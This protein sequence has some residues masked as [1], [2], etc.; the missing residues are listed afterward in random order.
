MSSATT[1]TAQKFGDNLTVRWSCR[2]G[3]FV[4]WMG[5]NSFPDSD[6]ASAWTI[7]DFWQMRDGDFVTVTNRWTDLP[8]WFELHP[9]EVAGSA[10]FKIMKRLEAG[11]QPKE[12]MYAPTIWRVKAGDRL[13]WVSSERPSEPVREIMVFET[14]ALASGENSTL[15]FDW[16]IHFAEPD[17]KDLSPAA[18]A[19]MRAGFKAAVGLG[20][21]RVFAEEWKF[22]G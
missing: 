12:S 5:T 20:V 16:S 6:R 21:P 4:L 17:E 1:P 9:S 13:V 19:A 10:V 2:G 8:P 22:G 18:A 15:G 7:R 14:C 3:E 11:Y